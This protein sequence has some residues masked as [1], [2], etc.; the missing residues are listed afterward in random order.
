MDVKLPD[1]TIIKNVPEGTTQSDLMSR[2]AKMRQP[3]ST[4]EPPTG[5]ESLAG[6]PVTRFALG[7]ASPFIGAAQLASNAVGLGETQG[8]PFNNARMAQLQQMVDKGRQ[9]TG[10]DWANAAGSLLPGAAAAK[11]ITLAATGLG[12]AA[13]GAG[14]GYLFG[15]SA[16]VTKE[17]NYQNDN[18]QQALTGAALGGL[19]PPAMDLGGELIKGGRHIY[20]GAIEPFFQAGRNM[21]EGRHYNKVAGDRAA[22]FANALRNSKSSVPGYQPTAAEIVASLPPSATRAGQA[23]FAGLQANV[24]P[25]APSTHSAV[26]QSQGKSLADAIRSFGGDK[27]SLA[28]AEGQRAGNAATN[29]ADAYAQQ[30]KANPKLAQL[31]KNPYIQD[32]MG[33]ALKIAEANGITPKSDLT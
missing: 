32:E 16:P 6:N 19:I 14:A 5:A 15:A 31:V 21:A 1:G 9:D 24:T 20:R 8:N 30:I 26:G 3:E 27:A 25:S 29:Y 33:T 2:L 23:E 11:A 4:E 13:Q 18:W 10:F 28:Q 12:R 17:G 7:G 22:E